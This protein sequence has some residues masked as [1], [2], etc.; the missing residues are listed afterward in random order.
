MSFG[1]NYQNTL[2]VQNEVITRNT[3]CKYLGVYID[4]K[5]TFRDHI[6]HV[7]KKLIVAKILWPDL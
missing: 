7:V 4:S 1:S 6:N 3:C 2:T 5:L